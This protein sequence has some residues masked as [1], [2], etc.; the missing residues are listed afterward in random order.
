MRTTLVQLAAP[1]RES[2]IAHLLAAYPHEGCGALVGVVDSGT[3]RIERAAGLPNRLAPS[4][5]DRFEI[6]PWSY[7]ALE[8]ELRG[9]QWRVIGFFHSHPDGVALPSAVDLEM[10]QGLFDV[11]REYFIYAIQPIAAHTAGELTFWQLRQDRGA[12]ENLTLETD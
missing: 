7:A 6:D 11:A 9:S 4:T 3:A 2:L 5:D 10:A 1:A 8:K 12:F